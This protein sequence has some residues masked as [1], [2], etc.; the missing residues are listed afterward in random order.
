MSEENVQI[1]KRSFDEFKHR[2]LDSAV[3]MWDPEGEWTPAMAGSVETKVYRW[4]ITLKRTLRPTS[5]SPQGRQLGNCGQQVANE[6]T[7][8]TTHCGLVGTH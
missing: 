8:T 6:A 2:R 4:L 5:T 1:V 7:L 3:D